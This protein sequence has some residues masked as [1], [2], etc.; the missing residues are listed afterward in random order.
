MI[1]LNCRLLEKG[2]F[3]RAARPEKKDKKKRVKEGTKE[4]DKTKDSGVGAEGRRRKDGGKEV[5]EKSKDGE[6]STV[7]DEA[8]VVVVC[9]LKNLLTYKLF[10]SLKDVVCVVKTLLIHEALSPTDTHTSRIY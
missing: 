2:F 5:A 8:S 4:G 9:V 7:K 1:H 6:K 10:F 3:Q